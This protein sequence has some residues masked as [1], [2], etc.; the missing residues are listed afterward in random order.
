MTE[1]IEVTKAEKKKLKVKFV[2]HWAETHPQDDN[3]YRILSTKYDLV[4]CDDPDYLFTSGIGHKHMYYDNCIKI[5]KCGENIVPDFN[6][7]DYAIGFDFME[8]GDRYIRVPMCAY[9]L[10]YKKLYDYPQPDPAALLKRDFCSFVVSNKNGNPLRLEFFKQLS[11]YKTVASGGRLLNNIGKPNGVENKLEFISNYKFNICFE[12]SAS[13]GYATEKIVDALSVFAVPIYWGNP[14]IERDFNSKSFIRVKNRD[15]VERAIE[16]VIALD[17]DDDAY[18]E[19]CLAP[20]IL[21]DYQK[22]YDQK[23]LDFLVRIIEQPKNKA[24]RL[25]MYGYQKSR[26]KLERI[27]DETYNRYANFYAKFIRPISNVRK[28]ITGLFK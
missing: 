17:K 22:E 16:E 20:R 12:N 8:F 7:Y 26:R 19:R 1:S 28:K 11:K 15:D 4:L 5:E 3:L 24:R 9:S 21:E 10:N 2:D 27:Y 13:M 25:N 6:F 18:L 14:L 23:I